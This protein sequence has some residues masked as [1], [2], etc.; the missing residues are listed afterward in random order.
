MNDTRLADAVKSGLT[1]ACD[2]L[3][4][5][6]LAIPASEIMARAD[7]ART[8]RRLGVLA[9]TGGLA[10][11][12][13]AV[14]V[15]LPASHPASGPGAHLAAWIVTRQ[16]DGTI[17]VGFFGQMRDP[18]GLQRTLRADGVPASVTVIGQQN[19]ACHLIPP[20]PTGKPPL[21]ARVMDVGANGKGLGFFIH[22]SALPSGDG[23]QIEVWHG[24]P[25]GAFGP[26][27]YGSPFGSGRPAVVWDLVKAS[28]Q[29]TGS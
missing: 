12:A 28:P 25:S 18:A 21:A 24:I 15:A 16:A 13:V 14:S 4:T 10:A 5:V 8:H 23:L 19:P 7:R 20:Q 11:V 1:E 2:S 26:W 22:P 17:Q 3:S 29:C 27:P 9:G 6:H